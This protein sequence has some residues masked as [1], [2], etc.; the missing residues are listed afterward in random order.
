MAKLLD[1]MEAARADIVTA[2]EIDED[3]PQAVASTA[4]QPLQPVETM[5]GDDATRRHGKIAAK[6]LGVGYRGF[7]KE[8]L[9][10]DIRDTIGDAMGEVFGAASRMGSK[11][12]YWGILLATLMP[13]LAVMVM[14]AM[15]TL[16]EGEKSDA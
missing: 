8:E 12:A 13:L 14:R 16:K 5:F 11:L 15:S 9:D 4:S 3:L 2:P 10:P 1:D 7:V 6:S